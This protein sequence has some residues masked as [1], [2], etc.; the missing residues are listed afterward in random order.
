MADRYTQL[1]N[2]FYKQIHWGAELPPCQAAFLGAPECDQPGEYDTPTTQ[3]PWADLC[4]KHTRQFAP[5]NTKIGY[6]RI[7]RSTDR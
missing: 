2:R 6:H 1:D 7:R 4:S 3:G 5:P